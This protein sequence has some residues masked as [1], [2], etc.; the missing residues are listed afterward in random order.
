[1]FLCQ[2]GIFGL[3]KAQA[4]AFYHT[5]ITTKTAKSLL[6]STFMNN[7]NN[8]L[9]IISHFV[10]VYMILALGWWTYLHHQKNRIIYQKELQILALESNKPISELRDTEAYRRTQQEYKRQERMIIGEGIVIILSLLLAIWF[11]YNSYR[12]E[13]ATANMKRNFLLSISHELKSPIASLKIALDTLLRPQLTAKQRST[14]LTNSR[15]DLERLNKLIRNLLFSARVD[16]Q[17]QPYPEAIDVREAVRQCTRSIAQTYP[18]Y[19]IKIKIPDAIVI[20]ADRDGFDSIV[21]NLIDNAIKYS[22][23]HKSIDIEFF[24]KNDVATLR[25]IDKGIGVTA[26]E[27]KK[28]FDRFYRVGSEDTRTTKGTGLGLYIVRKISEA[29]GWQYGYQSNKPQGSIFWIKIKIN[30]PDL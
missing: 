13:V 20:Y 18:D 28:I 4:Q 25:V 1:M 22:P 7:S 5:V 23:E 8:K 24:Q 26:P 19:N 27:R 15:Y 21:N 10:I 14:L 12:R 6:C 29:H 9:R 16:A 2:N 11:I 3:K 30:K 17:Y